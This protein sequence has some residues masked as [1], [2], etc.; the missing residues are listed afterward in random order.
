[1]TRTVALLALFTAATASVGCG[2]AAGQAKL[3]DQPLPALKKGEPLPTAT[4]QAMAPV[5]A[6]PP[7]Q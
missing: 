2:G 4:A 5:K 7:R 3:P 6:P 1:M